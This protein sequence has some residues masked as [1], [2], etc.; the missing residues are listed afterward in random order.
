MA[1]GETTL[2]A[3]RKT[4][5]TASH[6]RQAE[7]QRP[8]REAPAAAHRTLPGIDHDPAELAGVIRWKSVNLYRKNSPSLQ[9]SVP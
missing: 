3:K 5:S 4:G 1:G 6:W 8:D 7:D 2:G 9:R